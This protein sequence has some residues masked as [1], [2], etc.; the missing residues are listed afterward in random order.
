MGYA[1]VIS[2]MAD[3]FV[4]KLKRS[5]RMVSY[6]I[7]P[8]E[9]VPLD[10][11]TITFLL[12]PAYTMNGSLDGMVGSMPADP[13][14]YPHVPEMR[15]QY[16]SLYPASYFRLKEA[17]ALKDT[18]ERWDKER[19]SFFYNF[20]SSDADQLPDTPTIGVADVPSIGGARA[21]SDRSRGPFGGQPSSSAPKTRPG[22]RTAPAAARS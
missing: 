10:V 11:N 18:I 9:G 3:V 21:G 17:Y 14:F 6:D 7:R 16:G 8:V 2:G 13:T 22:G 5:G 12:N 20:N 19:E 1:L 4:T 15:S